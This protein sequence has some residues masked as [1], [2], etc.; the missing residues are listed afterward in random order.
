[1]ANGELIC[2]KNKTRNIIE[3]FDA[4]GDSLINFNTDE[5]TTGNSM[6]P[7]DK[8]VSSDGLYAVLYKY[9]GSLILYNNKTGVLIKI[10]APPANDPYIAK[11]QKNGDFVLYNKNKLP[12]W[13]TNTA[14]SQIIPNFRLTIQKDGN[15]V[16]YDGKSK[17]LWA[18]V[19]YSFGYDYSLN[20]CT[21]ISC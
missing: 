5:L 15:L 2:T 13:A 10:I 8:L 4:L 18:S 16:L 20:D 19:T 17:A 7:G 3:N 12:Y 1:M 6:R 14:T 9:D 21:A 11:L